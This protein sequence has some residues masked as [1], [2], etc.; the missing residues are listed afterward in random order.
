MGD[1][2]QGGCT[3]SDPK[4]HRTCRRDKVRDAVVARILD[5]RYPAGTHLKEMTLAKEFATSQSPVREALRE[6]EMLGLVET[7]RYRGTRVLSPRCTDLREAYELKAIIES[8]SAQLA[9]P[10]RSEDLDHLDDCVRAMIAAAAL[11]DFEG[12]S[13]AAVAFHRR[14]VS[15]SGN[16]TFLRTWEGLHWEVRSRIASERVKSHLAGYADA[17]GAVAVALR[18]GAGL[19]AGG[20]LVAIIDRFLDE[21]G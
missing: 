6:L 20:L 19:G 4:A 10:C 8:R 21:N 5:G 11:A 1:P 14:I 13:V 9:V 12:Y 3:G 18:Q 7:E 15:M 17:H 2:S 16:Q